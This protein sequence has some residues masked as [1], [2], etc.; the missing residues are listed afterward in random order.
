[1]QELARHLLA[2]GIQFKTFNRLAQYAFIGAASSTATLRNSRV[3]QS[4]VAVMTGLTRS[5][6]RTLLS[7]ERSRRPNKIDR[8]DRVV[9]AWGSNPK[10]LSDLGKPRRLHIENKAAGFSDLVRRYG[11]DV[12]PR[13]ML[14]ELQRRHIVTVRN[15][16]VSLREDLPSAKNARQLRILL[17]AMRSLIRFDG[18]AL[19]TNAGMRIYA[20]EIKYPSMSK[21][22]RLLL[23]SR[24]SAAFDALSMDVEVA[25]DAISVEAPSRTKREGKTSRTSIMMICHK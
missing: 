22:G 5:Q 8:V 9:E 2:S 15:K 19:P 23:D 4:T 16:Y 21:I 20:S 6:V 12:T 24:L 3:N 11:S 10:Y 25:G 14:R 1:M 18:V 17:L 7:K 13:A